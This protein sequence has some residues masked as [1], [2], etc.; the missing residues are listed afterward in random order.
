VAAAVALAGLVAPAVP[1]AAASCTDRVTASAGTAT[2]TIHVTAD[3]CGRAHRPTILC[4]PLDYP[5]NGKHWV[6]GPVIRRTGSSSAACGFFSPD[7]YAWGYDELTGG[8]SYY[9]QIGHS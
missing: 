3:S 7:A 1:A 4:A 9:H 8:R 6:W 2:I 5:I